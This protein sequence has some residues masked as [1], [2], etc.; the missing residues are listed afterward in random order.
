[1][2]IRDAP[3]GQ[4]RPHAGNFTPAVV[5]L[6]GDRMP[7]PVG[8][9]NRRGSLHFVDPGA[10]GLGSLFPPALADFPQRANRDVRAAD[11]DGD[12]YPDLVVNTYTHV[13]VDARLRIFV[14]DRRGGFAE[15]TGFAVDAGGR[16]LAE[17]RLRG[18]GETIV[19]ADFNGDGLPDLYVPYY[20]FPFH[21]RIACAPDDVHCDPVPAGCRED[22]YCDP[23]TVPE[24]CPDADPSECGS[25][26]KRSLLLINIGS[27]A[28]E[29]GTR[30]LRFA[31]VAVEAG[32]RHAANVS[33]M[34]RFKAGGSELDPCGNQPEGAQALDYDGDGRIDLFVAGHL[35]RNVEDGPPVAGTGARIPQFRDVTLEAG[36]YDRIDLERRVT[37]PVTREQ[38]GA[39]GLCDARLCPVNNGSGTP[40]AGDVCAVTQRSIREVM[41]ERRILGGDGRTLNCVRAAGSA[42]NGFR[43]YVVD[44][45]EITGGSRYLRFRLFEEGAKFLDWNNDGCPDLAFV[46]TWSSEL[47]SQIAIG[48]P[49]SYDPLDIAEPLAGDTGADLVKRAGMR[50]FQCSTDSNGRPVA[51]RERHFAGVAEPTDASPGFFMQI[52]PTQSQQYHFLAQPSFGFNIADLDGDGREDIVTLRGHIFQNT[53][54]RFV[55]VGTSAWPWGNDYEA[56]LAAKGRGGIGMLDVDRDGRI[57][58]LYPTRATED[59]T[60]AVDG[61][62]VPRPDSMTLFGNVSL[63]PPGVGQILVEVQDGAG[64]RNQHGR[65][66]RMTRP[67]GEAG[68]VRF[69]DSGSSYLS[70]TEYLVP[71]FTSGPERHR[72]DVAFPGET[73]SCWASA[74]DHLVVRPRG[75][76]CRTLLGPLPAAVGTRAGSSGRFRAGRTGAGI[77]IA[78]QATGKVFVATSNGQGFEGAWETEL[79]AGNR[80]AAIADFDGDGLSDALVENVNDRSLAVWKSTA[81]AFVPGVPVRLPAG[82]RFVTSGDFDADGRADVVLENPLSAEIEV[83]RMTPAGES[84]RI[85]ATRLDRGQVLAGAADVDGDGRADLLIEG[86]VDASVQVAL[87]RPSATGAIAFVPGVALP[88]LPGFRVAGFGDVN[89]D[90]RAEIILENP[91]TATAVAVRCTVTGTCSYAPGPALS[92][93]PGMHLAGVGDFD[94]DGRADLLVESETDFSITVVRLPAG[95]AAKLT[96]SWPRQR[97]P[98]GFRATRR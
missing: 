38:C 24:R 93:P 35:F 96:A 92:L 90:G 3:A 80:L 2:P 56:F 36:L 5:D 74:G 17:D 30:A 82:F 37:V 86:T 48:A 97:L 23:A 10:V 73:V 44:A 94:G 89:A 69:V 7:A 78:S 75:E 88:L 14:N 68:G 51:W 42:S 84:A 8:T 70:Q 13:G 45:A 16:P 57:D 53:G 26:A 58:L 27:V 1:M 19:V 6:E 31:E 12:G 81:N 64:Q 40:G 63:R 28:R 50:L 98:D 22:P 59:A 49:T 83:W 15:L 55:S 79:P 85:A 72:I 66:I 61:N 77:A 67:T 18:R 34:A 33:L 21:L 4:S 71:V 76:R 52:S 87:N 43:K 32:E 39:T 46:K 9:I 47:E 62:P 91:S 95:D 25:N 11:L 65:G 60:L 54:E 20:T 29:D 41:I